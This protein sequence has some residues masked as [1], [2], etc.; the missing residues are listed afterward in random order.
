MKATANQRPLL[1][2][3]VAKL[4]RQHGTIWHIEQVPSEGM[5]FRCEIGHTQ[6]RVFIPRYGKADAQMPPQKGILS[7]HF[8]SLHELNT[9]ILTI[10]NSR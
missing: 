10:K 3:D 7:H 6:F 5:L 2:H 8:T 1:L 9:W 4:I